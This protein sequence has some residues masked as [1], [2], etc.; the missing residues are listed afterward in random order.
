MKNRIIFCAIILLMIFALGCSIASPGGNVTNNKS[1]N[2]QKNA[3]KLRPDVIGFD[4]FYC[5]GLGYTYDYRLNVSSGKYTGYCVFTNGTECLADDF[6]SGLCHRE[7]SLC[8][9]KGYVLKIGVEQY[10]TYNLTYP[11]CIFPDNSYCRET[12]FFNRKCPVKW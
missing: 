3:S 10:A 7:F 1:I 12:D 6:A 8:E 9:I 11:I 5:E 4:V 2:T